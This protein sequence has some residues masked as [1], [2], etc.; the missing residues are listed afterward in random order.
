MSPLGLDLRS[1]KEQTHNQIMVPKKTNPEEMVPVMA[2]C[3]CQPGSHSHEFGMVH[4]LR[5]Y[6]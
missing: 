6:V 4:G 3:V 5:S 2:G 1:S